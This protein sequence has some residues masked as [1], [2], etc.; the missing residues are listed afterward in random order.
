MYP[1]QRVV[2]WPRA[3]GIRD[4]SPR[5]R[6]RHPRAMQTWRHDRSHDV[7]IACPS[8]ASTGTPSW[9]AALVP[10]LACPCGCPDSPRRPGR[11]GEPGVM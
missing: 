3:I 8:S 11:G 9:P 4:A 2:K 6:A 7:R 1:V 5:G 10:P